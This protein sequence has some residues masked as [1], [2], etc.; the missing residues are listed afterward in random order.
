MRGNLILRLMMC[1]W[2]AS[3]LGIGKRLFL[4]VDDEIEKQHDNAGEYFDDMSNYYEVCEL[5]LSDKYGDVTVGEP[6]IM[7][8][9]H[10]MYWDITNFSN[11]MR[12]YNEVHEVVKDG[13]LE[14]GGRIDFGVGLSLWD[15]FSSMT[16]LAVQAHFEPC[17]EDIIEKA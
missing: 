15:T 16:G 17:S 7:L 11:E 5:K 6:Y 3:A 4:D 14:F 2:E 10:R 9:E 8:H 12:K 13:K 1:E